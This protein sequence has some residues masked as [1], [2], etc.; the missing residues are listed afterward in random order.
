MYSGFHEKNLGLIWDPG[1]QSP[2][3]NV[4][5]QEDSCWDQVEYRGY[6]TQGNKI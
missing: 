3:S 2:D 1:P 4:S 6:L 5:P